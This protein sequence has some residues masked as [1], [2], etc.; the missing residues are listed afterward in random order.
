MLPQS[1]FFVLAP[2]RPEREADL[3]RML[4]SMNQ[5]P[6]RLKAGGPIP[7]AAFDVVHFARVLVLDDKTVDDHLALGVPRPTFPLYLAFLGDVDGD[8]DAF[9]ASL[10]AHAPDGLRALF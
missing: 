8:A 3:R 1:T 2:I 10:A 6:G 7:F 5:A 9:L 4:A